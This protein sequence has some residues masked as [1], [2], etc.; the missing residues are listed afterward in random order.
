MKIDHLA[1]W[2]TSLAQ[3]KIFYEKYFGAQSNELYHNPKKNF[4]SYFLSFDS[5]TR[6]ELMYMQTTKDPHQ[7]YYAPHKGLV[8]LAFNVGSREKVDAIISKLNEDGYIIVGQP[9]VTGDGYYEGVFLDPEG[10]IIEVV[11]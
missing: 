8:H 9:R 5:G 10:N 6:I 7:N 11:A 2:V 3:M 1:I 4:Y